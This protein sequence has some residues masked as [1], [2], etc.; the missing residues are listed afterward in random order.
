MLSCTQKGRKKRLTAEVALLRGHLGVLLHAC[1]RVWE[2]TGV[3]SEAITGGSLR[4][5]L[6]GGVDPLVSPRNAG[7][8]ACSPNQVKIRPRLLND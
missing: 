8:V 2:L 5:T 6:L 4:G 7:W 3:I 1:P